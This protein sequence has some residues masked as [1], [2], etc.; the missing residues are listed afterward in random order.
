[1]FYP[2]SIHTHTQ[3]CDGKDTMAAMVQR[4]A[5]MGM[6]SLGFTPHSPLPYEN[7][8]A[9]KEEDYPAF[10]SELERLKKLYE[11]G[12]EILA[13]IEWDADTPG[14]PQTFDFDYVIG[15]LHSL[16]KKGERF[17]VDYEKELLC[18]VCQRLYGGEFLELCAD[19]YA[20][21]AKSALRPGVDIVAHI[22][23]VTKYNKDGEMVNETDPEYL[24]MAKN[25]IGEILEARPE[26]FFEIN[27]GVMARA[28]KAFPYPAPA[29]LAFL[30]REG[31][32]L[33]LT[34]DCH[35]T[36]HLGAG[37][38]RVREL[39]GE[40]FHPKLYLLR[41]DGFRKVSL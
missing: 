28:G 21:A 10:F 13:G 36:A 20:Q 12:M 1:M 34:G 2:S 16:E 15:A 5:E 37:Y 8:W 41:K 7:D 24:K 19:Y 17:S 40:C 30:C 18:S 14:L 32:R 6:V 38:D 33:V 39:L 27:T 23:L 35:R 26:I 31:A 11:P 9:M 4:A 29:L 3:F 25:C 22:D